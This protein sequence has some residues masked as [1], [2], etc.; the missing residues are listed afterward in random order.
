M[1]YNQKDIIISEARALF[2]STMLYRHRTDRAVRIR[3]VD[4][5][6]G[7][8]ILS[9]VGDAG[10][11]YIST[12]DDLQRLWLT[13][14]EFD[15]QHETDLCSWLLQTSATW[16]IRAFQSEEGYLEWLTLV[17]RAYTVPKSLD[18][19]AVE[20]ISIHGELLDRLHEPNEMK[21]MCAAN[22]WLVYLLTLQLSNHQLIA[23]IIET[24]GLA[25][26]DGEDGK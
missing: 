17:V 16:M 19:K 6:L 10:L 24:N 14:L 15:T 22:P 4:R 2:E 25:G 3:F 18:R 21:L 20:Y 13:F 1:D 12:L 7:E 5:K 9:V 11:L 26:V 8:K 23:E